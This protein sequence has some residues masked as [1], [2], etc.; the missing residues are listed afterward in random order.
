MFYGN[1]MVT[2]KQRSRAE[3]Q[4]I[5]DERLSKS[6][7]KTTNLKS[8]QKWEKETMR[9]PK[10]QKKKKKKKRVV[11]PDL[12]IIIQ[13]LNGLNPSVKRHRMARWK[14]SDPII[15]CL[16]G[17]HLSSNNTQAQSERMEYVISGKW[18]PK[19]GK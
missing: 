14:E 1:L 8:K 17:S 15:C 18:N 4:N 16:Q 5:K 13:E 19:E 11:N 6:P 7:W 2:T 10:N 12:S 9:R 3:T